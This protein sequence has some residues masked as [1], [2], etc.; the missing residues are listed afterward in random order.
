MSQAK[1]GVAEFSKAF[2]SV[3]PSVDVIGF[4]ERPGFSD[5]LKAYLQE[6]GEEI[7]K[8]ESTRACWYCMETLLR[9]SSKPLPDRLA[10][11]VGEFAKATSE[12][13]KEHMPKPVVLLI[14]AGLNK[15]ERRGGRQGLCQELQEEPVVEVFEGQV[16]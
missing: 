12:D 5:Q 3:L 11:I 16:T 15:N 2:L 6:A 13:W 9:K 4:V 14:E 10:G 7:G 8:G 1:A